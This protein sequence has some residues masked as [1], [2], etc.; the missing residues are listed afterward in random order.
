MNISTVETTTMITVRPLQDSDAERFKAIR[1][2]ATKTSPTSLWAT[3]EEEENRSIDEFAAR[4]RQ[5]DTQTVFG[6]F[7]ADSLVGVTGVRREPLIQIRHRAMIW[8]VFVDP[9]HRRQRIAQ[10]LLEAA[11]EHAAQKWGCIQLKLQVNT[12][13]V[14]AKTLYVAQG[15]VRFGVEPRVLRVNGRFYDEEYM[16]KELR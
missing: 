8:G 9:E 16:L 7:A 2:L 3:H 4:I 15:F 13:N 1:V 6:A 11:A 10:T 12:E 5:T 14:A